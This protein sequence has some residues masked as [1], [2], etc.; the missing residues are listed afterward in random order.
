[1]SEHHAYIIISS[2]LN[3]DSFYKVYINCQRNIKNIDISHHTNLLCIVTVLQKHTLTKT[4]LK[5]TVVGN[6]FKK[7]SLIFI[8]SAL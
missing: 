3:A 5:E 7:M 4:N 1:M 6:I 2:L 8:P